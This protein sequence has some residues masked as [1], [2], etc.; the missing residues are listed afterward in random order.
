MET[1][2]N[3]QIK[4]YLKNNPVVVINE[5]DFE[6]FLVKFGGLLSLLNNKNIN[7]T[8]L[9]LMLVRSKELQKIFQTMSGINTL[10]ESLKTILTMYPNLIKSKIVKENSIKILKKQKKRAKNG[11]KRISKNHI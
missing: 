4:P 2:T 6:A 5:K 7:P 3:A 1:N 8:F 9:F 11:S 10:L